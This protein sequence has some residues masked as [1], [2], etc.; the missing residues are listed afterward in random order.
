M[1]PAYSKNRA[2]AIFFVIF[3]L[4]GS[5]FLMNLLTAI[6]YNQFRGYLMKSL[7]TSLLRRRLG[8][9]AAYEVLSSMTARTTPEAVGVSLENFQQVL[10]KTQLRSDQ[11]Q[12]IMEKVR[13]Y[14]GRLLSVDQFQKLFDEVDKGVVPEPPPRP[15]YQSPFLQCAQLIFS[16]SSFDHLGNLI[17]L[18]NLLSICVFLALDSD[19]LPGERDDFVLG[20]SLS[21]CQLCPRRK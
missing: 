20:V 18:G 5:L 10:Q 16:H 1:I 17:A 13:T 12:A 21:D 4:I 7:Q 6:I 14:E 15:Q 19:L 11:K 2:Y 8:T 3:T 9:R